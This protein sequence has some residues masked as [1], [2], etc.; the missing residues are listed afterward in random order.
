[1]DLFNYRRKKKPQQDAGLGFGFLTYGSG[2]SF[3]SEKA[4][5]LSTVYRCV[6]LITDSVA[7]LPLAAYSV[8]PE[9]YRTRLTGDARAHLLDCEPNAR[10]TRFSFIKTLV[11]SML[12]RGNGYAYI[13]RD[14]KG[15]PTGLH[16]IPAE[17]VVI[18]YPNTLD[19]PVRYTIAGKTDIPAADIIHILNF[20]DNGVEGISTIQHAVNSLEIAESAD[21]SAK[22]FFRGGC[23]VGGILKVLSA[24]TQ[25][26]KKELKD[27]W[28]NAFSADGTPNGVAVLEGN[29]EYHPTT[30][31]PKDAMLLESRQYSVVDI[32]RFFGVSPT[33]CYD[34]SKSSYNTLEQANLS[35]LTDTLSPILTK[36]ELEFE[37]KLF[38]TSTHAGIEVRFDTSQY[39]R[40][41]KSAQ[42]QFY[43]TLFNLGAI[44][45]NEIRREIDLPPVDA[46]NRLFVQVNMQPLENYTANTPPDE[47]KNIN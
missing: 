44:T 1:M 20:S 15:T 41:D 47:S 13:S 6:E 4:M 14:G 40:A 21:K 29:M 11:A 5:L 7:Q 39:L 35:F 2:A 33:K 34:L 43:S 46:G 22:G 25:R 17:Y 32:C 8:T 42:A 36:I 30:V 24:L 31:N 16:L 38:P 28:S 26:Q 27:S 3:R 23:N 19:A 18:T 10:M 9:G 37:R 45:P 12:L